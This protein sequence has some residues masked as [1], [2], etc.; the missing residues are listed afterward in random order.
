MM[1]PWL[2]MKRNRRE[3][4][5]GQKLAGTGQLAGRKG[6]PQLIRKSPNG[7]IGR[8]H[9]STPGVE[10]SRQDERLRISLNRSSQQGHAL[11]CMALRLNLW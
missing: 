3:G 10:I 7:A 8:L 5:A 9:F 11:K 6:K 2:A 1:K 4:G